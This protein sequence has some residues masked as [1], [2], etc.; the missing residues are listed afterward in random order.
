VGAA[1]PILAVPRA[2]TAPVRLHASRDKASGHGIFPRIPDGS[3]AANRYEP[4]VLSDAAVLYS[5]TIIHPSPK[6][7]LAPFALAY[8]DFPE[9]VRV[10]GRLELA[11]GARPAIG[12]RLHAV[13]PSAD[14]GGYIFVPVEGGEA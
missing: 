3:P 5:Y 10:F 8:A 2:E 12:M 11:E 13:R 1:D 9:D 4:I 6:S 7:G 14:A